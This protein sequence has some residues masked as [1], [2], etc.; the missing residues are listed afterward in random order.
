MAEVLS[1]GEIDSLLSAI[2]TGEMDIE[3]AKNEEKEKKVKVY[4]FKRPDK[5]SKDQLRT[6]QMIHETFARLNTTMLSAQLR[7]SVQIQVISVDQITYE[8]F[9]RSVPE[10]T[11][12]GI[13]DA[14]SLDGN[15]ILELN[16]N[17]AFTLID[18]LFGGVGKKYDVSR[19]LTDIEISIVE[20]MMLKQ[21]NHLKE[22]WENITQVSPR[23]EQIESNSQ[24]VQIVG[25]NEMVILITFEVKIGDSEGMM[26]LCFPYPMIE[27][28]VSK[29]SAQY[30]FSNI[31]EEGTTEN[32][33]A[34]RER[35]HLVK[36]PVIANLG[37]TQIP[38]SEL[39][40]LKKG[41][42]ISLD[43]QV[44]EDLKIKVGNEI[45]FEG[46]AGQLGKKMAVSIKKVIKEGED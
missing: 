24:F 16:P 4:D 14:G 43:Q 46:E 41:D 5:L 27:P 21:L 23:I 17:I 7:T 11:I 10:N 40:S 37:E 12:M 15:A 9:I 38:L 35:L 1:Q 36:V 26:N 31:R 44:D 30:W 28:V 20:K 29:L 39:L 6:L 2:S 8:E 34:L 3:E 25:P 45:K 22:A 32:I 18:R 42:V 13:F 19:E 33:K